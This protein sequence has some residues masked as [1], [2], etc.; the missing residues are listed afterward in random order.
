VSASLNNVGGLVGWTDGVIT[1]TGYAKGPVSGE[2]YVG[3]LVG[4]AERTT[5]VTGYARNTVRR[6]SGTDTYFGKL[7]GDKDG[8]GG[9]INGYNSKGE[10][11]MFDQ[12]G[13]TLP[14]GTSGVDGTDLT[15]TTSTAQGAFSD[16]TFGS[17]W[18]WVQN[19]WWPAINIGTIMP[20]DKQPVK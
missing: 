4:D 16:F 1:V 6:K 10:S 11:K 20:K 19:G 17:K 2:D 9:T 14:T 8:N 18:E 7:V 15:M 13:K 5:T 12:D 3:G